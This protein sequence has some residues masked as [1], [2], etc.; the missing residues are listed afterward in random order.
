MSA[1][2]GAWD[3]FVRRFG[4][5]VAFIVRRELKRWGAAGREDEAEEIFQ[6]VFREL[7]EKK[8]LTR[9]RK[10]EAVRSFLSAL[11]I[12]RTIDALR[13]R[14]RDADLFEALEEGEHG[15]PPLIIDQGAESEDFIN[16]RK[17]KLREALE[18]LPIK[19]SFIIRCTLFHG[20][21]P[22]D[23]GTLLQIPEATVRT[24]IRR[25]REKMI[26]RVSQGPG[27]AEDNDE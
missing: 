18:V 20:M 10:P 19:E 5:L 8:L 16:A 12:S 14:S 24:H 13:R 6:G 1:Q 11:C 21:K 2:P 22:S 27:P 23:V 7:Y 25:I 3:E 15:E 26:R 9:L 17:E 4:A